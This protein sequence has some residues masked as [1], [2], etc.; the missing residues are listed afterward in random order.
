MIDIRIV[1]AH[2]ALKLAEMLMRLLEAEEH[3]VR[4]L[5]G[6]QSLADLEPAKTTRD[7][8]VLIWSA[9][10]PS[11]HY[12]REWARN[13]S[14]MR[15]VEIARAP[16][17][18]QSERKAPVI[19]FINWRG[20]RGARAWNALNDRL[21][22]VARVME[23]PKP[24]QNRAAMALGIASIAAVTGAAMVRMHEPTTPVA[25]APEATEQ[26]LAAAPD[27]SVGLG[28]PLDAV[29]PAS[30]EELQLHRLPNPRFVPLDLPAEPDLF[31]E[32][33]YTMAE[34]P[35]PTLLE[36]L[37]SL[38]PLRDFGSDNDS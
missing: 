27:P 33:D 15:L 10:A 36:R 14:P 11:Q 9:N 4:L 3:Q 18:P 26:V 34:L 21:R 19:D 7:A 32:P 17:W 23:P 8:V 12:M 1:C 37:A 6:R 38:N 25:E 5:V 22:A 28:G 13:I 29:E 24:A 16:G 20:E 30:A 35:P 31:V 2:D